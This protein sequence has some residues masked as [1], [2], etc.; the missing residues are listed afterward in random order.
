M[1]STAE[2]LTVVL[3]RA[4]I[5]VPTLG[6]ELLTELEASGPRPEAFRARAAEARATFKAARAAQMAGFIRVAWP[7]EKY[8]L[9]VPARPR[10]AY[11]FTSWAERLSTTARE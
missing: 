5:E 2:V 7:F 8:H 9:T 10:S 3:L 6:A 4:E 1:M 11:E